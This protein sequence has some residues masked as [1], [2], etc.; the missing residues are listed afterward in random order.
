MYHKM[1]VEAPQNAGLYYLAFMEI[2]WYV[3]WST[4][5]ALIFNI[6]WLTISEK[7]SVSLLSLHFCERADLI[8][9]FSYQNNKVK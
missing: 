5:E 7:V 9:I 2:D 1:Q 8:D 4:F 6:F 3:N